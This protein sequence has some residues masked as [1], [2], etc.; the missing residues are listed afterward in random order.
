M[1]HLGDVLN[2]GKGFDHLGQGIRRD[3][4]SQTQRLAEEVIHRLLWG[5]LRGRGNRP[6]RG[7]EGV[8]HN[9]QLGPIRRRRH[10]VLAAEHFGGEMASPARQIPTFQRS[11]DIGIV[12]ND[13]DV[14]GIEHG[15]KMVQIVVDTLFQIH[16]DHV[17]R[18]TQHARI[19]R[20]A[21]LA[22][23]CD[24]RAEFFKRL[25]QLAACTVVAP[26]Q[27]NDAGI[28]RDRHAAPSGFHRHCAS[29]RPLGRAC[30][31]NGP[32]RFRTHA[33]DVSR[34]YAK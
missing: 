16:D 26:Q 15:L 28:N 31:G 17:G 4:V 5:K 13:I 8:G 2:G 20:I 14:R 22:F 18:Y 11:A 9:Q 29:S 33:G 10:G 21:G 25:T 6:G 34:R 30:Q 19:G 23:K 27:R 12:E 24:G 3:F 1:R 32:H 7:D